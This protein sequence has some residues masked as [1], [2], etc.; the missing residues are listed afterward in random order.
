MRMR[1]LDAIDRRILSMLQDNGK[2]TNK[3]IANDLG[4]S[5][6]PIYERIK[7]MEEAGYIRSYT[8]IVDK[9]MLG[10]KLIAYCQVKLDV[11]K[12]QFLKQFEQEVDQLDEVVECYHMTGQDDYLLKVIVKDMSDYQHFISDKLAALDNI[13]SV[14]SSFVM[15]EVKWQ[16]SVPVE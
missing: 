12:R 4:M 2:A 10:Y 3:E 1:N 14:R 11:H 9:D 6:T 15:T 8:A 7:K 13:G 16:V 5:I